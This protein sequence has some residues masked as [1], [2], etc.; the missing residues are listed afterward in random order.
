MMEYS[1]IGEPRM[2]NQER[3]E[4]VPTTPYSEPGFCYNLPL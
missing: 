1:T 4:R 2:S 3:A